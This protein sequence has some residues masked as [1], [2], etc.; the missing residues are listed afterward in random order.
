MSAYTPQQLRAFID[1]L[2]SILRKAVLEGNLQ[3]VFQKERPRIVSFNIIS[4]L[5]FLI[6]ND[7]IL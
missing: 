6:D 3:E 7:R 4:I 1:D 5:L 2:D